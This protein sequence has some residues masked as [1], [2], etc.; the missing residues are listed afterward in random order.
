MNTEHPLRS[1]SGQ[2]RVWRDRALCRGYRIVVFA[3]S[4]VGGRFADGAA[5]F[6]IGWA[7]GFLPNTEAEVLGLWRDLEAGEAVASDLHDRG[8]E[9]VAMVIDAGWPAAAGAALNTFPSARPMPS[10]EHLVREVT[11]PLTLR[12]RRDAA[13]KLRT[14]FDHSG[15]SSS[16]DEQRVPEHLG[17][18]AAWPTSGGA[19]SALSL[20]DALRAL[21]EETMRFVLAADR[22]ATSLLEELARAVQRNGYFV[23]HDAALDFVGYTLQR[24]ERRMD[25]ERVAATAQS[26]RRFAAAEGGLAVP[27]AV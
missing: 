9:R 5:D 19:A 23:N 14:A 8:V 17:V 11:T 6:G 10:T 18:T 1:S 7:I 15:R 12:L 3:A 25:R 16:Y 2:S 21:P 20:Q 26:R 13:A 24:A 27:R 4:S 22:T